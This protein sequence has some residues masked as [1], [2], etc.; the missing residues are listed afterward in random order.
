MICYILLPFFALFV[1][2]IAV[3]TEKTFTWY[4]LTPVFAICVLMLVFAAL[5]TL[6]DLISGCR[7]RAEFVPHAEEGI[8]RKF[9]SG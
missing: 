9:K 7:E 2:F 8:A 5:D 1:L 6:D 4:A 3:A